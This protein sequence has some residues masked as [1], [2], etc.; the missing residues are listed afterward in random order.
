MTPSN[1]VRIASLS[2]VFARAW[3]AENLWFSSVKRPLPKCITHKNQPDDAHKAATVNFSSVAAYRISSLRRT[4][5]VFAASLPATGSALDTSANVRAAHRGAL[6]GRRPLAPIRRGRP[7]RGAASVDPR[8]KHDSPRG[9]R[10]R[11]RVG[12]FH[13][14]DA[15][16]LVVP[17]ERLPALRLE[18]DLS[19]G[20][21]LSAVWGRSGGVA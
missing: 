10:H 7:R 4:P 18:P 13:C 21:S 15:P 6:A 20:A 3:R 16:P 17:P 2:R 14:P 12:R 9:A 1:Y 5:Y 11:G 8:L 19:V